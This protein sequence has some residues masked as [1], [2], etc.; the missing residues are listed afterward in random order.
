MSAREQRV[1]VVTGAS[2]GVGKGVACALADAGYVV[3]GTGRTI[4]EADLRPAIRAKTAFAPQQKAV[5]V[6][7]R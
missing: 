6:S 2:R 4:A 1:A 5:N 7:S 3:Y